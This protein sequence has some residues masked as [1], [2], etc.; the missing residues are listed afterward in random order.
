MPTDIDSVLG[1]YRPDDYSVRLVGG[2]CKVVPFAPELNFY[3][4]VADALTQAAPAAKKPVLD[5]AHALAGEDAAQRVLWVTSALDT[6]DGGISAFSGLRSAVNL[7]RSSTGQRL[8][9][10]ETDEAQAADAV[11][12]G[13]AIAYCVY[14]LYPGS[15]TEKVSAFR[16]SPTGQ[17]LAFYYASVELGLPFADNALTGG[18]KLLSD[19][20]ARFGPDQTAKFAAIAGP[21]AAEGATTVMGQLIGP[22]DQLVQMASGHLQ[23]VATTV[24]SYLPSALDVGDKAAGVVATAADAMPVYRW[25]GARLVTEAVIAEALKAGGGPAVADKAANPASDEIKYTTKL[26]G[27]DDIVVAAPPARRRW[28][29]FFVFLFV[30]GGLAAGGVVAELLWRLG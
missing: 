6:A 18:G 23:T 2:V 12:K 24:T 13:L 16:A 11:L 20:Y 26:P 27:K 17:A 30:Q 3:H 4:S 14:R 5:R 21:E 25:M 28:C 29:F 22:M 1:A 10:L 15:V 9:A 8:A 7:V 19:L